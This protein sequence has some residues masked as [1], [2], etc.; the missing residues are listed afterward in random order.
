MITNA[1]S[2]LN[3]INTNIHTEHARNIGSHTATYNTYFESINDLNA[4]A[5]VET[6][7]VQTATVCSTFA[8]GIVKEVSNNNLILFLIFHFC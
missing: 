4:C 6:L 8:V 1:L 2:Y 7:S 3:E 5:V